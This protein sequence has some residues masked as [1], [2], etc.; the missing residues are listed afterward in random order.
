MIDIQKGMKTLITSVGLT[1]SFMILVVVAVIVGGVLINAVTGGDI[2][3]SS[4]FN[5]VLNSLDSTT[6]AWFTTLATAGTTAVGLVIVVFLVVLF[7]RYIKMGGKGGNK[8]SSF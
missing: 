8:G 2:T 5:T 1:L 6:S 7:R 4:G 3:V